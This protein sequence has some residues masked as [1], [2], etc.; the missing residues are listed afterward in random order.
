VGQPAAIMGD[1][2]TGACAVHQVPNPATGAP[3]PAPPMPFR[4]PLTTGLATTVLVAG[5]PAAVVGSSGLNLPPHIGLHVSDPFAVP[6]AQEGRVVAGSSSVLVEGR[7]AA[8]T[9]SS[10]TL[11]AG[12]PGRLVGSAASVLVGG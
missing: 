11:C 12:A 7:A 5:R 6:T 1:A 9:G 2:V 10:V 3:Q 4:A 8:S